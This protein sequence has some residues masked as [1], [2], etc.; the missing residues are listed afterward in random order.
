[1][2]L[3]K[4]VVIV[5][6]IALIAGDAATNVA[7]AEETQSQALANEITPFW[8]EISDILPYITA[9]GTTLYPE[10][11]V[12]AISS[13]ASISGTMYLQKYSS[14]RWTSVTSWGF[15]GTGDVFLSKSYKGTS[16]VE[17][18]TKVVVTV[19]G[20]TAEATSGSCEI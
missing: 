1:M 10:V 9:D 16:G 15:S 13:S 12:E 18:R 14:G 3:K 20:E 7:Y 11:Y 2:K 5:T 8:S 19:N 4:F 6:A 17:Y